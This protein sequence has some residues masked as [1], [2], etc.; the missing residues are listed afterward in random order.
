MELPHLRGPQGK[1]VDTSNHLPNTY[2][3]SISYNMETLK[4]VSKSLDILG[5][6]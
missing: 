5:P 1:T 3:S 6:H 4:L 2:K